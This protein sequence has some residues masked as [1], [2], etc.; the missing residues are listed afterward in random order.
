[1]HDEVC[2]YSS[3]LKLQATEGHEWGDAG[4]KFHSETIIKE[5]S[6]HSEWARTTPVG[7]SMYVSVIKLC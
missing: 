3:S 4:K 5:K 7:Q 2:I 6:L 1:M